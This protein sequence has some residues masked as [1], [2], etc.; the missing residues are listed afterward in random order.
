M[1]KK[2]K[3][4]DKIVGY[5]EGPFEVYNQIANHIQIKLEKWPDMSRTA[6]RMKFGY[7]DVDIWDILVDPKGV[8]KKINKKSNEKPQDFLRSLFGLN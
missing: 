2:I 8:L 5:Q 1:S 6:E 3:L 4:D 7:D